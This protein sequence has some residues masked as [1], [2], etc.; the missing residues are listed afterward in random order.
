M[1]PAS[2]SLKYRNV[3]LFYATVVWLRGPK[4]KKKTRD[5]LD[6]ELSVGTLTSILTFHFLGLSLLGFRIINSCRCHN[7][8]LSDSVYLACLY[9]SPLTFADNYTKRPLLSSLST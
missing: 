3:A 5:P 9:H 7:F 4:K 1:Q 2:K 6:Q 8:L